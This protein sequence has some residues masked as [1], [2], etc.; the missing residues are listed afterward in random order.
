M[1]HLLQVTKYTMQ[2][3]AQVN[4]LCGVALLYKNM[5]FTFNIITANAAYFSFKFIT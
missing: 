2:L 1:L 3:E 4:L 5:L